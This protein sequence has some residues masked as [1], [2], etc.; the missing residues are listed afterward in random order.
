MSSA[1]RSPNSV[2]FLNGLTREI[3]KQCVCDLL[4]DTSCPYS[5]MTMSRFIRL[6][7]WMNGCEGAWP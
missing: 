7:L 5:R 3:Q 4:E 6:K 1:K 2:L